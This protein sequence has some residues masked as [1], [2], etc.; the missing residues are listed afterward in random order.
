MSDHIPLSTLHR[1]S[2]LLSKLD[3]LTTFDISKIFEPRLGPRLPR[4]VL[5]NLPLP[6]EAWQ[7]DKNGQVL[8]GK[9]KHVS[10][11]SHL[12][13]RESFLMFIYPLLYSNMFPISLG[14]MP[15]TRFGLR[16]TLY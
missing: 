3:R 4:Q 1:K 11:S 15:V 7:T 2:P 14:Y 12:S 6:I 8:I 16:N 5:V 10:F 13:S 9:P